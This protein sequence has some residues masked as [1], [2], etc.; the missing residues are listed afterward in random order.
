MQKPKN[1][2]ITLR[3]DQDVKLAA[4]EAA[5]MDRRSLTNLVELLLIKHCE[6]LN[7]YPKRKT[8][9]GINS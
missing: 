2:T 5:E 1:A 3:I 9:R 6:K 7:L 4:I 8:R